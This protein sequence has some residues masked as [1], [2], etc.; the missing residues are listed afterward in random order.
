MKL[1]RKRFLAMLPVAILIAGFV[2]FG[3]DTL[4][5]RSTDLPVQQPAVTDAPVTP[6]PS[7]TPVPAPSPSS[8]PVTQPAQAS[9]AP[10]ATVAAARTGNLLNIPAI[11][12][13]AQVVNVGLTAGNAIDVPAGRQVGYWTGSSVPGTRG[14]TFLDGHVDGIF[15]HLHRVAVGQTFSVR[16][17]GQTYQYQVA[18]TETVALAG[19]DM[20][21]ALSTFNGAPEGLNMMTCA[22]NYV[23][24]IGTYD[25]RF[26]VYAVR[27]G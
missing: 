14:A 12:L 13:N 11:G 25:Q 6:A 3:V 15:A 26:V 17:N 22:G 8:Q 4:P 10:Q 9:P 24:A 2:L 1:P 19:I 5:A 20:N 27:I 18:H 21:R 7:E 16:F 23:P